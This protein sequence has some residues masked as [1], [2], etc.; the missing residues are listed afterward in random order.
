MRITH[1]NCTPLQ[2]SRVRPTICL[3]GHA[4]RH[5]KDCLAT[6]GLRTRATVHTVDHASVNTTRIACLLK[7]APC[8]KT[9][10]R[11]SSTHVANPTAS[12]LPTT[13][14]ADATVTEVAEMVRAHREDIEASRNSAS[15]RRELAGTM[16]IG[17]QALNW[18]QW[19]D[20][21]DEQLRITKEFCTDIG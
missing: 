21:L 15:G 11:A 12:T 1:F 20:R 2:L 16:S 10:R 4:A 18:L 14:S 17:L 9:F 6:T 5:Q 13:V 7:T 19:L 3:S 8:Q